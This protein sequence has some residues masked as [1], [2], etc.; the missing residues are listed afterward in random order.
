MIVK[1]PHCDKSAVVN[2]LGRKRLNIAVIEVCDALQLPR[3]VTVTATEL[4]Y[5][6]AYV[7]KVLKDNG[8][9]LSHIVNGV[10]PNTKEITRRER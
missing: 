3:S 7:Y 9:K 2:G 5:S 6:R 8:L 4:G 10:T 1:C